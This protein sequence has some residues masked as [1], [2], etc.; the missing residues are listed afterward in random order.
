MI[1]LGAQKALAVVLEGEAV[2]HD[3]FR[4]VLG[5]VAG[6]RQ[7]VGR[8][9]GGDEGEPVA[10]RRPGVLGDPAREVGDPLRLAPGAVEQ[11]ELV[12]LV[13][14]LAGGEKSEVA[15]VG[16]PARGVLLVR[17][18]G[19]P[20]RAGAVPA[21]H[22]DVLVHPVPRRVGGGDR[23]RHPRAVGRELRIGDLA[24][25]QE[26]AGYD[27]PLRARETRCSEYQSEAEYDLSL[28]RDSCGPSCAESI[29]LRRA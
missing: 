26:V 13:G 19:D 24:E 12:G 15:P 14:V 3:R 23:V 25:P 16:A 17:T 10:V 11:P 22:P 2:H 9:I 5:R 18:A 21:R 7:G 29:R 8:R 27:R 28:H 4:P 6:D 20:H 1:P